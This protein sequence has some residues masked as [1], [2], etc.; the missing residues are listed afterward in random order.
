VI[1]V[2]AT[3]VRGRW[4]SNS[5]PGPSTLGFDKPDVCGL[6]AFAG[7]HRTGDHGTSAACG[8]VAG[9][10][11]LLKR[12]FP[13]ASPAALRRVL[14]DTA[15]PRPSQGIASGF[16]PYWGAGTVNAAAACHRLANPVAG[17]AGVGSTPLLDLADGVIG[18]APLSCLRKIQALCEN[19]EDVFGRLA[20]SEQ[21]RRAIET[22]DGPLVARLLRDQ[23]QVALAHAFAG[24][25][26]LPPAIPPDDSAASCGEERPRLLLN[27]VADVARDDAAREAF[28]D[29]RRRF[30]R[31]RY[32]LSPTAC[33]LAEQVTASALDELCQ[34]AES[35]VLRVSSNLEIEPMYP[36][37]QSFPGPWIDSF[38]PD[39]AHLDEAVA[40][41]IEGR[42]FAVGKPVVIGLVERRIGSSPGLVCPREASLSQTVP[43]PL[44]AQRGRLLD[45]ACE[46]ALAVEA[47]ASCSRLP[48]DIEI[49]SEV[50]GTTIPELV[51]PRL[52]LGTVQL[53][54]RFD[55]DSAAPRFRIEVVFDLR[56][57]RVVPGEYDLWVGY[58]D[59]AGCRARAAVG[60]TTFTVLEPR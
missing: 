58:C 59:A 32:A 52:R 18:R 25:A 51:P 17:A 49:A 54:E 14:R 21:E 27:L 41:T 7:Y 3:D 35:E 9:V 44:A 33:R 4:L 53:A 26:V 30:V 20:L 39:R 48:G 46:L 11:A 28:L 5:S 38:V 57:V 23:M 40:V 47:P 16:D 13:G 55:P 12:N 6:A 10:V 31:S 1:S 56:D 50:C 24:R 37:V 2:G 36:N 43:A 42:G 8:V 45:D 19:R 22:M 15:V 60:P 29:D 34:E